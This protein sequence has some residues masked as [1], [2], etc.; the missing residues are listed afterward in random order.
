MPILN[1]ALSAEDLLPAKANEDEIRLLWDGILDILLERVHY[2]SISIVELAHLIDELDIMFRAVKGRN[3]VW[4]SVIDV[5]MFLL[6]RDATI[7]DLRSSLR[8]NESTLYRALSRL[9]LAGLAVPSKGDGLARLW[10]LNREKCPV[11]YRASRL[12]PS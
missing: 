2:K 7:N 9:E 5:A 8:F 1:S 3:G 6:K 11:L 10:T 4:G 12:R